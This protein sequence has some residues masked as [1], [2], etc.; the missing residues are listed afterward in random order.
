MTYNL[1]F[2]SVILLTYIV[3]Q[4]SLR[5]AMR[6]NI[7]HIGLLLL[8]S[9]AMAEVAGKT[10][11]GC[12]YRVING[13]YLTSCEKKAVVQ[14][15]VV[16]ASAA[17]VAAPVT[18]YDSVPVRQN[19]TA[20]VPSIQS[21]PQAPSTMNISIATPN[22]GQQTQSY[23]ERREEQRDAYLDATYV[24]GGIGATTISAT[25]AGGA[26]GIGLALGTNLDDFLGVEIAYS[27]TKQDTNLNLQSRGAQ[28]SVGTKI[29]QNDSDL[30]SHLISAEVQ[31]HLTDSFKRLRPY[32][33]LG[34]G[35]KSSTL[36]EEALPTMLFAQSTGGGSIS[37]TSLGAVASAGTK[38][39]LT[40]TLQLGIAFKYFL[41]L[42]RQNARLAEASG[43]TGSRLNS[44]DAKLTGSSQH[45]FAGSLFYSF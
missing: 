38:F 44:S 33:G 36:N 6:N 30:N 24:G 37:Q 26:T 20:P 4:S 27:Y 1:F 2:S 32:A 15:Q 28:S 39:R 35:W 29:S 5:N 14:D 34:L 17:P 9:P 23:R 22:Q 7:I 40:Q 21:T 10:A 3:N 43:S 16:V 25:N 19:P 8:A 11:D 45:Q 18:S 42:S 31:A 41:P 13:Q 12:S